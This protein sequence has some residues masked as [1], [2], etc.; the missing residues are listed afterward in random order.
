LA[1][2]TNDSY[3]KHRVSNKGELYLVSNSHCVIVGKFLP[4]C[5]ETWPWASGHRHVP[6]HAMLILQYCFISNLMPMIFHKLQWN[7]LQSPTNDN[8]Q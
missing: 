1:S 5:S 8:S 3:S 2:L 7:P 4:T 6:C